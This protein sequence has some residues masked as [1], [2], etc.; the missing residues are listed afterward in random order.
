[1]R[2][3]QATGAVGGAGVADVGAPVDDPSDTGYEVVVVGDCAFG[4]KDDRPDTK[5]HMEKQAK[6]RRTALH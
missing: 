2:I 6:H 4:G 1:M 3:L 5:T